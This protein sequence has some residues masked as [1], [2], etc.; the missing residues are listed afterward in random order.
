MKKTLCLILLLVLG[1]G[2]V[3]G[4]P[5]ISVVADSE[6]SKLQYASAQHEIISI[7]LQE[8]QFDAVLSE[9]NKILVLNLAGENE[10]FV[11]EEV[12]QIVDRLV[13]AEQFS[14]AHKMITA[15]LQKL[16]RPDNEFALQ[17]LK[18]K[19]YKEQGL[20]KEALEVYR[21]AQNPAR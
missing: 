12:W 18:G 14:L 20:L 5:N 6:E 1:T 3:L 2:L 4:S 13:A 19:V 21:S 9:F 15:A 7:L 11:V 17:M 8:G 10:R 16:K